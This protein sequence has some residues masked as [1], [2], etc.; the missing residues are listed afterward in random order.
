MDFLLWLGTCLTDSGALDRIKSLFNNFAGEEHEK[1]L[2]AWMLIRNK[3]YC[4]SF[5][6][7]GSQPVTVSHSLQTA[8]EAVKIAKEIGKSSFTCGRNYEI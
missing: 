7:F 6:P 3:C 5:R 2:K 8:E 1:K 4:S